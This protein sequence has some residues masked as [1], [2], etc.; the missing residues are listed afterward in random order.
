MSS[1]GEFGL[2]LPGRGLICDSKSRGR[3]GMDPEAY[4]VF[5]S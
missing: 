3:R 4:A 2:T 5:T 1:G